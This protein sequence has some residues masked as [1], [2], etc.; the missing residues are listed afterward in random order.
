MKFIGSC[1]KNKS[2]CEKCILESS[3]TEDQKS[4]RLAFMNFEPWTPCEICEETEE[5]KQRHKELS[6]FLERVRQHEEESAKVHR[7]FD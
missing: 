1:T 2:E 3:S 4:L 7:V 6:D 5:D